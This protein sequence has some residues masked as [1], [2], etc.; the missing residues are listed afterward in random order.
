M[1]LMMTDSDFDLELLNYIILELELKIKP[2]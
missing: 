1:S 2:V